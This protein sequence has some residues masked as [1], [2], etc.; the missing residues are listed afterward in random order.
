MGIIRPRGVRTFFLVFVSIKVPTVEEQHCGNK[1]RMAISKFHKHIAT[2][3]TAIAIYPSIRITS[4]VSA[5]Q[6][7]VG[8]VAV[9]P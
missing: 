9:L 4:F 7:Q 6:I 1:P 3:T 2:K 8:N 5:S